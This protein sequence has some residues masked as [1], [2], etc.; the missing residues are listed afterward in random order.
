MDESD[1]SIVRVTYLE[2]RDP[3]APSTPR[4]GPER[5]AR[6]HLALGEYLAIYRNVGESLRWDQRLRMPEAELAALLEGGSLSTYVLRNGDGQAL[7]F[8]EF[9][10][11][12]FPQVELKN[13]GLIP[14]AQGRRVRPGRA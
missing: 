10:R 1:A 7:G 3:P 11:R 12:A 14:E 4:S 8:C 13:F 5:I 2:L 6:E 9:D